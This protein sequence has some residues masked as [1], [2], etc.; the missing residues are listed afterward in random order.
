MSYSIYFAGTSIEFNITWLRGGHP[1]LNVGDLSIEASQ[2][3]VLLLDQLRFPAVK[4]LTTSVVVV[5]INRYD[6]LSL[7]FRSNLFPGTQ[8]IVI[9]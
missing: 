1:L 7:D 9:H 6:A 8:F 4:S 3:L 2:R 5:I